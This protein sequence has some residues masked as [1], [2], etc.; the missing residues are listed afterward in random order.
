MRFGNGPPWRPVSF[1][2]RVLI[3]PTGSWLLAAARS[4]GALLLLLLLAWWAYRPGLSGGFLFDDFINLDAL[5]RDGPVDGPAALLRYLT[6]GTADPIGRPLSLLTF[7]LD[8]RD[9]P[10]DPAPFLQTNLLLHL[11]N[12]ALLFGLLRRLE[13]ILGTVSARGR[14]IAL[15]AT[16]CWLLHP[17]LVS[18]TLYVVQREAMLPATCLLSGLL[19]YVHG[20]QR[21][22]HSRGRQGLGWMVAG[23]LG[24]GGLGLLA[25]ANGVLMPL[26]A[27]TLH[28]SVL[29][30]A[31]R[32][33][34][35]DASRR[36]LARTRL[37][38]IVAPSLLVLGYA[39]HFLLA[40]QQVPA[41]RPWSIGQRVLTEP[42]I[43]LDYLGL[44]AVPRAVSTGLFNDDYLV[45]TSLWQPLSTLPALV[46]VVGLLAGAFALRARAP[47]FA[48]AVLFFFAGHLLESGAIPLELYFEHRN[49]LPALLLGWPLAAAL[50]R[51]RQPAAL[52]ALLGIGLV[53]LLAITTWQRATL[54]GHP[55]ALSAAWATR[56]PQSPRAQAAWAITMQQAGFP[57]A[58]GARLAGLWRAHPDDLQIALNA[59]DARCASGALTPAEAAAL[60]ST[61]RA[62]RVDADLL[63]QWLADRVLEGDCGTEEDLARWISAAAANPTFNPQAGGDRNVAPLR[64]ALALRRGQRALALEDFN[65]AFLADPRPRTADNQA[66]L[67]AAHGAYAE[68]LAHLDFYERHRDRIAPPPPGMPWIHAQVLAWQDYW[69]RRIATLRGRITQAMRAATEAHGTR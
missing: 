34:V 58:A 26:L 69:P 57:A 63:R 17:L 23:L 15:L 51:W 3:R 49:Y 64:A 55:A 60:A 38:L 6:S 20:L 10:A 43:L 7:L 25:K 54:W 9:W 42:R 50:V 35:D 21:Y 12:G 29:R 16:A 61:L 62:A 68:A 46:A 66:A 27:W 52:R 2:L 28:G 67:L 39:A 56:N 22:V 8:A 13:A 47:R 24:G 45:S 32:E 33:L 30:L 53:A 37:A 48:A 36:R 40:W 59:I 1:W 18:T 44:L 19:A 11:L 14:T 5:G 4:R 41:G 31:T 65:R